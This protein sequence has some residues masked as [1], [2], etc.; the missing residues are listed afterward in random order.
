MA[1]FYMIE[2][3][4]AFIDTVEDITKRIESTIR[5]VTIDLLNRNS[6][7][8]HE[9]ITANATENEQIDFDNYFKWLHNPFKTITYKEASDILLK[10]TQEHDPAEGLSK[11]NELYLVDHLKSPVFVINWPKSLKP[12]YMRTCKNDPNMVSI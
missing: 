6:K 5:S 4:E 12:F 3:E 2:A 9:A 1:E 8:I 10:H 7:E 11:N